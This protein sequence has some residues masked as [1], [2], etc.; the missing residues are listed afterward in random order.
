MDWQL[1]LITIILAFIGL[2][3]I[4][5]QWLGFFDLKKDTINKLSKEVSEKLKRRKKDL[6]VERK[7][8]FSEESDL[9]WVNDKLFEDVEKT[10][11]LKKIEDNL[12][13]MEN[14]SKKYY[15]YLI[16]NFFFSLFL[17]ILNI[18][19]SKTILENIWDKE[20]YGAFIVYILIIALVIFYI[21]F[22]ISTMK[23]Y[24]MIETIKEDN[25]KKL[26][27]NI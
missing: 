21:I 19:V 11:N 3:P 25:N 16:I 8:I 17:W 14:F 27:I 18:I 1:A 10:D 7:R 13:N 22:V 2:P 4:I 5:I 20:I 12:D 6:L 26:T 23:L 24:N 15:F 9:S